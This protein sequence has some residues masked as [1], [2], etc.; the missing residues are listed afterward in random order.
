[1]GRFTLQGIGGLIL[2]SIFAYLFY[3]FL[4][5]EDYGN[6]GDFMG[7]ALLAN[8]ASI[9]ILFLIG[10][11][12]GFVFVWLTIKSIINSKNKNI[13]KTPSN[14][15]TF[16]VNKN[17]EVIE[18]FQSQGEYHEENNLENKDSEIR[19]SF[20]DEFLTAKKRLSRKCFFIEY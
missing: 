9:I 1:M 20:F 8:L 11:S 17:K 5:V 2:G 3:A 6:P 4:W 18:R 19:F 13:S 7:G 16:K 15:N 14:K 12:T 10:F